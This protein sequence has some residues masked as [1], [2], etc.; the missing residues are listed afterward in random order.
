MP[1]PHTTCSAVH[2]WTNSAMQKV[3]KMI[4]QLRLGPRLLIQP[5]CTDSTPDLC[6][7]RASPRIYTQESSAFFPW[8]VVV[9]WLCLCLCGF[10]CLA[11]HAKDSFKNSAS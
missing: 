10:C 2:E 5:F 1:A 9:W 8:L 6:L 4:Q 11:L 3:H 7:T